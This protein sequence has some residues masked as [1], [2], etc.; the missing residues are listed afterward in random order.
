MLSGHGTFGYEPNVNYFFGFPRSI[1]SGGVALD[2]PYVIN[3]QNGNGNRD[4]WK[5]YNLE[6][7]TFASMLEHAIP[8]QY[9]FK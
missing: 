4:D 8:E 6:V 2:I 9:I 1:S 3:T 5:N 7:G